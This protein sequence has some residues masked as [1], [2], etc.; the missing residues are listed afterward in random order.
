MDIT[1]I[2]KMIQQDYSM[3]DIF[4]KIDGLQKEIDIMIEEHELEKQSLNNELDE[5]RLEKYDYMD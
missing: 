1:I 5:A 4:D 3:Q 2:K